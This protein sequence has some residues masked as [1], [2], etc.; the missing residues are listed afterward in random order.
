MPSYVVSMDN[1]TKEQIEE[2]KR[3]GIPLVVVE[4]E[5]YKNKK[6]DDIEYEEYDHD[7]N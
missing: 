6:I 7:I 5:R 3:L 4:R 1:P 2:S